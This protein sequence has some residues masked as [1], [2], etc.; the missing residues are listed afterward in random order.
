M[1]SSDI[2]KKENGLINLTRF[3]F[4]FFVIA[5]HYSPL[6]NMYPVASRL[7]TECI[8]R[9]AVPFYFVCTG[10]F[11]FQNVDF[12]Y[13]SMKKPFSTV[14]HLLSLYLIWSVI[15]LPLS[16]EYAISKT[17]SYFHAFIYFIHHTIIEGSYSHLW[18][19]YASAFAVILLAVL[20]KYHSFKFIFFT[21]P[22]LYFPFCLAIAIPSFCL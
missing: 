16:I 22:P 10:F 4:C 20:L 14:K 11:C 21:V 13:Y 2:P 18:Y 17:D 6:L 3:I 1:T 8:A 7:I 12:K 19:L 5:I 9:I 15:Y